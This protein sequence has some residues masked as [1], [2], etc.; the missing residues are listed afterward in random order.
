MGRG[1]QY[2]SCHLLSSTFCLPPAAEATGA[3]DFPTTEWIARWEDPSHSGPIVLT[4]QNVSVQQRIWLFTSLPASNRSQQEN[5][6]LVPFSWEYIITVRDIQMDFFLGGGGGILHIGHVNLRL[7]EM[8]VV[9][10]TGKA[11]TLCHRGDLHSRITK[12]GTSLFN[13]TTSVSLSQ[14]INRTRN[15]PGISGWNS[16]SGCSIWLPFF[17]AGPHICI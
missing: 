9:G 17:S 14:P 8:G 3:K 5:V 10:N 12:V 4:V 2:Y 1:Q 13:V 6:L 16:A 15:F 7:L 11:S